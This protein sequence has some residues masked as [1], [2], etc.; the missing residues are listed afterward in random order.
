VKL[1]VY[2]SFRLLQSLSANFRSND[3]TSGSLPVTWGHVTSFPA[4]WLP[5]PA[6]YSLVV[7]QMH[8]ICQFWPSTATSRLLPVKWCHFRITSGYVRSR[9]VIYCHVTA[10]SCELQPCRKSNAQ[11]TPALAFYSDFKVTSGQMT[12]LPCHFH[13]TSSHLRSRDV[14]SCYVTA[15]SCELQLCRKSNAQHTLALVFYSHFQVTFAQMTSLP[16]H[17]RSPE[18]TWHHFLSCDCFILRATAL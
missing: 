5:P 15:S 8:S 12:S 10:S 13:V 14:I 17:F 1:T 11:Y 9:D 2:S 6:R 3:V 18:V 4:A 16:G 7:S